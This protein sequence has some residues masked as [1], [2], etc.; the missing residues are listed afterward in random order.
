MCVLSPFSPVP[1]VCVPVPIL[2]KEADSLKDLMTALATE[3]PVKFNTQRLQSLHATLTVV[4]NSLGI[5]RDG[6][7]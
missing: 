2:S 3:D 7:G 1:S 4:E 5:A 6:E